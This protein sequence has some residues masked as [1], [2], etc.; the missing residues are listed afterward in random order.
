[1]G[2]PTLISINIHYPDCECVGLYL[3]VGGWVD[4]SESVSSLRFHRPCISLAVVSTFRCVWKRFC[5]VATWFIML[6]LNCG[7]S[8][9]TSAFVRLVQ[10]WCN[11]KKLNTTCLT[12]MLSCKINLDSTPKNKDV[13][14]Q[15]QRGSWVQRAFIIE[16]YSESF[17]FYWPY[18]F[19]FWKAS[20]DFYCTQIGW[21]AN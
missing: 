11:L 20:L 2:V 5:S 15:T 8:S 19:L 10:S 4:V 6:Q 3:C 1:M 21:H 13:T 17:Y 18:A 16:N 14:L 12:S 9:N 7:C